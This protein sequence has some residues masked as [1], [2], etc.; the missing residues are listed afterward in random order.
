M[1]P[2]S[3]QASCL[4]ETGLL[5]YIEIIAGEVGTNPAIYSHYTLSTAPRVC[6]FSYVQPYRLRTLSR[7]RN[8][9]ERFASMRCISPHLS[10][11][12]YFR[13]LQLFLRVAVCRS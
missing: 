12:P 4:S 1:I 6:H 10:R 7:T 9:M 3:R 5:F 13:H 2:V 8:Y 11:R